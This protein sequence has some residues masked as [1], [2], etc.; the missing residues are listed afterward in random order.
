MFDKEGKTGTVDITIDTTSVDTGEDTLNEH[1]AGKALLDSGSFPTAT[2]K[3]KLVKFNGENPTEVEGQF[4]LKGVTK[5]LTLKINKFTCKPHP[6]SRKFTCGA[7]VSGS[8]N[9]EDFGVQGFGA[10]ETKLAISVE[11]GKN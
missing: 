3:G 7:D 9:R 11:A 5:P 2:Y 6:M 10:G 8:F 4:T 1:L